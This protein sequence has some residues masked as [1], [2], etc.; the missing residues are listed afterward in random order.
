MMLDKIPFHINCREGWGCSLRCPVRQLL[1]H[2]RELNRQVVQMQ[3]KPTRKKM[4]EGTAADMIEDL[5]IKINELYERLRQ[6][7]AER[8][9]WQRQAVNN[10]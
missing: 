4:D 7:E 6:V 3:A 5:Q 8:D 2:A 1:E 10:D 9:Q